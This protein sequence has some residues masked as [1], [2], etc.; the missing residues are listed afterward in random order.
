MSEMKNGQDIAL[1]EKGSRNTGQIVSSKEKPK[2]PDNDKKQR[3]GVFNQVSL[4]KSI[5]WRYIE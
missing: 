4:H 3:N 5:W 1:L 2:Q